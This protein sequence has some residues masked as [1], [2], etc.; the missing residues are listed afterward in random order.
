[1]AGWQVALL[2]IAGVVAVGW[3]A[4]DTVRFLGM[5]VAPD[6]HDT[7]AIEARYGKDTPEAS[8]A[9]ARRF[10][11]NRHWRDAAAGVAG[12]VGLVMTYW[13]FFE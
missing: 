10:G 8:A 11:R 5:F 2:L 13:T 4:F 1:M 6:Q 3:L 9:L 7:D 12:I